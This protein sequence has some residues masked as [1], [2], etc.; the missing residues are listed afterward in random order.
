MNFLALNLAHD[1]ITN[2]R[3]VEEARELHTEI[4]LAYNRGEEH[5]YTKRLKFMDGKI[6]E[7]ID[8][9]YSPG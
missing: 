7:T 4:V 6:E 8:P 3:S 9:D 5:S 2:K 1:I